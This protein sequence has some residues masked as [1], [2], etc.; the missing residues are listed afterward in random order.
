MNIGDNMKKG[1]TLIEVIAVIVILGII[2]LIA[3]P[4]SNS[5]VKRSKEK[6]YNEQIDKIISAC[7]NYILE[8]DDADPD[9]NYTR[10]VSIEILQNTGYLGKEEIIDP[11]TGEVING[12][13][14]VTYTNGKY[15]YE[16]V[17]D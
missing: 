11:K 17:E 1:F 15:A 8:N 5:A 16:Y 12:S 3:V 14:Q 10:Y 7:K 2:G 9:E 13:I 4:I 6:L